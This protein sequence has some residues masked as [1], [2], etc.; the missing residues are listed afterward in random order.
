MKPVLRNL[1][2]LVTQM[3]I[4]VNSKM[5]VSPNVS[6]GEYIMVIQQVK[7]LFSDLIIRGFF[8]NYF[9]LIRL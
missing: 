8:K 3:V 6:L 1:I 9:T 2:W 5:E 4:V 7:S